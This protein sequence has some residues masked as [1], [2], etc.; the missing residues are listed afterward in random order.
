MAAAI[1]ATRL[2]LRP[3]VVEATAQLGGQL[4]GVL[5]PITDYPGLPD[6]DGP[7]LAL[8]LAEHVKV[9]Q[10]PLRLRARVIGLEPEK[11][12][13][14]LAG[15]AALRAHA[16]IVATGARRRHLGLGDERR[17]VG[18]GVSYSVSKDLRR[19]AGGVAVVVGGGDS[20]VEGAARLAELCSTVHLVARG[21]LGARPDFV[22][23]ALGHRNVRLHEGRRVVGLQGRAELESVLLDD[24]TELAC[25]M[26]YVRI[27]VEP[28]SE[29]FRHSF[30]CDPSGLLVVDAHQRCRDRVYAVGDVCTPPDVLAVAVAGGQAMVACKHIQS[31]W[32]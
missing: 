8:R 24:G 7:T 3:L 18:R 26:L 15:G 4:R 32:C 28:A 5:S 23:A 21:A 29:P 20:A 10:V 19:A 9:A 25:R 30:R 16:V 2:G 11:G 6:V 1:W 22:A 13:V 17:F 12:R 14:L 27:G 31:E